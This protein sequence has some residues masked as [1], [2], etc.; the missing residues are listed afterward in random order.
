MAPLSTPIRDLFHTTGRRPSRCAQRW[1]SQARNVPRAW[2]PQQFDRVGL[3]RRPF[4]R[5]HS[6]DC[7]LTPIVVPAPMSAPTESSGAR[8]HN[9]RARLAIPNFSN[10]RTLCLASSRRRLRNESEDLLGVHRRHGLLNRRNQLAFLI[11]ERDR[12]TRLPPPRNQVEWASSS[13]MNTSARFAFARSAVCSLRN[14]VA[15]FSS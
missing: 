1:Y 13:P 10:P 14:R 2:R 11:S 8:L 4:P 15:C 5:E 9:A 3:N 7:D 12:V 6:C